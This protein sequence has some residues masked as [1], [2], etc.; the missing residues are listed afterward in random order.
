MIQTVVIESMD[1]LY[2]L[3]NEQEFRK[4]LKRNRNLF[5]YR[6]QP[7][8]TFKLSTSL[9]RNCGGKKKELEPC[10]LR[11][12]TKYAVLEEPSIENSIWKQMIFGQH[13]G[14]P[15]RLLDW[16][17]SPLIALHFSVTAH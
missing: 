7:D 14:L 8:A 16:S 1:H 4:D 2:E 5:V 15:T 12:F 6:G 3:L 9:E 10:M 13:H 17:F 11:N